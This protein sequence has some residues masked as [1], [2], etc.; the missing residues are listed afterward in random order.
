MFAHKPAAPVTPRTVYT[1]VALILAA[2][3]IAGL[4][5]VFG[6]R[7]SGRAHTYSVYVLVFSDV[8]LMYV[9]WGWSRRSHQIAAD[10][11]LA[12]T[13]AQEYA[14]ELAKYRRDA[15]RIPGKKPSR[16]RQP[17]RSAIRP[18]L[19]ARCNPGQTS[20]APR[21]GGC[22]DR[23]CLP[24]HPGPPAADTVSAACRTADR[25]SSDQAPDR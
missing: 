16:L 13:L 19:P 20:R 12:L 3:F 22:Q 7:L 6:L 23:S 9:C 14:R 25:S 5:Q 8:G 18:L 10:R 17:V 2:L 24:S 21:C 4:V 11:E 1:V 15:L